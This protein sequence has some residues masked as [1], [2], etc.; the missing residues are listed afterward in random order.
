MYPRM[1]PRICPPIS[2]PNFPD[3]TSELSPRESDLELIR[4]IQGGA[5][6][7]RHIRPEDR[8]ACVVYL[9]SEGYAVAEIAQIL[10][11]SD[12]TV[13]RDRERVRSE[14]ALRP[15]P[16]LV[17]ELVGQ[18]AAEAASAVQRL[19]RIGR[20]KD[21]PPM[22]RVEAERSAW[23]VFREFVQCLQRLGYL[24]MAVPSVRADVTHRLG[25]PD[26]LDRI[27]DMRGELARL[28]EIQRSEHGGPVAPGDAMEPGPG[29]PGGS[30][31]RGSGGLAVGIERVRTVLLQLEAGQRLTDLKTKVLNE[32]RKE[33]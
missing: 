22:A 33:A 1:Y 7:P 19:R 12:R 18:L 4:E 31:G 16:E 6:D 2:P 26:G 24:P 30:G 23:T 21:A 32:Q 25:G 28:E 13:Q 11:A 8:R 17:C 9:T 15:S 20:D 29:A 27:E 10:R 5:L 14:H 3:S